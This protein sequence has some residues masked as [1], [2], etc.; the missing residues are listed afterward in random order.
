MKEKEEIK[1]PLVVRDDK[2]RQ[3][4]WGRREE[5]SEKTTPPTPVPVSPAPWVSIST[6]PAYPSGRPVLSRRFHKLTQ[7]RVSRT[8]VL[9]H[10]LLVA[11]SSW[12]GR[13]V[14]VGSVA[15]PGRLLLMWHSSLGRHGVLTAHRLLLRLHVLMV[16]HLLLL[17]RRHVLRLHAR[18]PPRHVRRWGGDLRMVRY[19]LGGVDGGLALDTVL[20]TNHRFGGIEASL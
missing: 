1:G 9:I 16:G 11:H 6:G 20:I 8:K 12:W 4:R 2:R 14:D 13:T 19:V 10:S 3:R 15:L 5:V 7:S 18:V 17:L